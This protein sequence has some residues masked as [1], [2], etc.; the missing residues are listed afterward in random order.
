MKSIICLA[1]LLIASCAT[2]SDTITAEPDGNSYSYVSQYTVEIG[3]SADTVWAHLIDISSWMYE[4]EMALVSGTPNQ[5]GEVR[6]LYE[7]QD[8]LI[9]ITKTIPDDLL[10]ISNLPVTFNGESSTGVAVV[11]LD[12]V[13]GITTVRVIMSRRYTWDGTGDNPQ[14]AVRESQEFNERTR[15]MWENRFLGRLR[16]LAESQ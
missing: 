1:T 16:E 8:F 4:F 11:T 2:A 9:Q 10:V 6:R 14:K 15:A 7:G 13:E 5:E 12:E 3:A